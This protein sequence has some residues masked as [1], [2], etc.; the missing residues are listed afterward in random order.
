[1]S[2]NINTSEKKVCESRSDESL[3]STFFFAR[4]TLELAV[5][6]NINANQIR[7]YSLLKPK[8]FMSY[9]GCHARFAVFAQPRLSVNSEHR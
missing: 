2:F 3:S 6:E 1:M 4:I 9:L 7:I 8:I 5:I